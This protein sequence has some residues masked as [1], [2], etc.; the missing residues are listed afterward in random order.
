MP[1]VRADTAQLAHHAPHSCRQR[2]APR[3]HSTSRRH[4][5]HG[6]THHSGRREPDRHQDKQTP[7]P[8]STAAREPQRAADQKPRNAPHTLTTHSRTHTET[9]G[10]TERAAPRQTIHRPHPAKVRSCRILERLT[11]CR[12]YTYRG[13]PFLSCSRWAHSCPCAVDTKRPRKDPTAGAVEPVSCSVFL[14]PSSYYR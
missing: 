14:N 12:V 13:I 8:R 9:T 2:T 10:R 4:S 3:P 5:A 7:C 6:Q 1:T 11:R